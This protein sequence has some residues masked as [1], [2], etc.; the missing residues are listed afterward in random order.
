[1]TIWVVFKDGVERKTLAAETGLSALP[2]RSPSGNKPTWERIL[3]KIAMVKYDY[4][5]MDLDA[6]SL[7]DTGRVIAFL[8]REN[9]IDLERMRKQIKSWKFPMRNLEVIEVRKTCEV[10]KRPLVAG[11][12]YCYSCGTPTGS[13]TANPTN[14]SAVFGEQEPMAVAEQ[15]PT[16]VEVQKTH[17]EGSD[18][19]LVE[20][21]QTTI[22][23]GKGRMRMRE[24][25]I[26]T[27]DLETEA[28]KFGDV[29]KQYLAF[30]KF[31]NRMFG[32]QSIEMKNGKVEAHYGRSKKKGVK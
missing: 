8:S 9:G 6:L 11:D 22:E 18:L 31:L 2:M 14:Q 25:T 17:E 24:I 21:K 3:D 7:E 4:F 1:M 13:A 30:F 10:C 16:A 5:L 27:E 19:Q 20:A 23:K 32:L 12:K 28:Q 15:R 26:T 29:M